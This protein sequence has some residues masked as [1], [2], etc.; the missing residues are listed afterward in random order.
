MKKLRRISLEDFDR[1]TKSEAAKLMGGK[2]IYAYDPPSRK[3]DY[4]YEPPKLP[5]VIPYGTPGGG[6]VTGRFYI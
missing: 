2:E 6:G 1:I 5:P 4:E 3:F